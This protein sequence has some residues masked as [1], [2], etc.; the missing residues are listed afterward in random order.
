[1]STQLLTFDCPLIAP[2]I[3]INQLVKTNKKKDQDIRY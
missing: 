3:A 2:L 1:M